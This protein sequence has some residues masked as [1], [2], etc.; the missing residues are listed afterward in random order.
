MPA[1]FLPHLV[2][3]T[4]MVPQAAGYELTQE[5]QPLEGATEIRMADGSVKKITIWSG[6]L[7]TTIDGNGRMPSALTGEAMD[8]STTK[9]L[10]CVSPRGVESAS[11]I[12][13]IPA[14]HR[15]DMAVNA[16]GVAI[17]PGL[18][19]VETPAIMVGNVVTLTAVSGAVRYCALYFPEFTVWVSPPTESFSRDNTRFRWRLEALQA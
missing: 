15:T 14:A 16:I 18:D 12:V 8:F 7:R 6:K 9:T 1:N 10:K 5:Y 13:T 19:I 11:N 3:G 4:V 17:L 2:L